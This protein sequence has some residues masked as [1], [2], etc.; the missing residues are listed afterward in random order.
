MVYNILDFGAVSDGKTVNT[1]AIQSAVDLCSLNGGGRVSIPAGVFLSGTIRLKSNVELYLEH[2]SVLRASQNPDDYNEL[3]EY[4]ENSESKVERWLGKHFILCVRQKNVAITG[5]GTIDGNSASFFKAPKPVTA[6]NGYAWMFGC[7]NVE[8]NEKKRP[9]QMICFIDSELIR[10]NGIEV[11][12]SPCWSIFLHGSRYAQL[13]GLRIF[14]EMYHENTDGIDI[15]TC[16][17]V[18]VS[19][20]IIRTGDDAVTVR[21]NS[22]RLTNGM[23][24]CKN[25]AITN[26]VLEC[27]V[28]AFRI[29]VGVG[30]IRNVTVSN[31]SVSRSGPLIRFMTSYDGRGEADIENV[32]F[33]NIVAEKVGLV[34]DIAAPTAG[35]VKRI[36]VSNLR[37]YFFASFRILAKEPAVVRDITFSNLDLISLNP[38]YPLGDREREMRG[39]YVVRCE[40]AHNLTFD[41]VNVT[42]AESFEGKWLG[43]TKFNNCNNL[44]ITDSN[45][46]R[47]EI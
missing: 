21:C 14:N 20:C 15:D 4:P 18:T 34:F 46:S 35:K 2:G 22:T 31:I 13:T 10:L 36:S 47:S 28:C 33:S 3:D 26:C 9:G 38:D 5:G 39:D 8:D 40:N 30:K 29:G 43:L 17:N 45:I 27:A 7:C 42:V 6:V 41:K 12:N 11:I 1:N 37:A 25:I 24:T 32:S 19:D 23:D 44:K 16:E